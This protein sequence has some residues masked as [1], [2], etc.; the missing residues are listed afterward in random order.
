[1]VSL[2]PSATEIVCL[3][4]AEHLL[5]GRS[6]ECDY[7]P[8]IQHLPVLTAALNGSFT[9][10]REVHDATCAAMESGKGLYS[11]NRALLEEL[12]PTVIVTQDLCEVHCSV[13]NF[14]WRRKLGSRA[15]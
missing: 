7:P 6:H 2:L 11:I 10:S 9:T 15:D 1:V 5:V 8:S 3:A 14:A 4:G 12:R 13:W